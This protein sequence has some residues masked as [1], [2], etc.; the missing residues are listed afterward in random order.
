MKPPVITKLW[1]VVVDE[2]LIPE[3]ARLSPASIVM[4][5]VPPVIA[6]VLPAP[7]KLIAVI[8]A[9]NHVP[10]E[11]TPISLEPLNAVAATVPPVVVEA[12]PANFHLSVLLTHFKVLSP[13]C[14]P[15][16]VIPPPSAVAFDGVVVVPIPMLLSSTLKV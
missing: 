12:V 5:Q 4:S 11:E 16:I 2:V 7:V 6:N 13:S 8:P 9:P 1:K 15:N 14:P 10:A 3:S